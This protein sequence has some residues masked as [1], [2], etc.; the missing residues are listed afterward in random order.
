MRRTIILFLIACPSTNLLAA[1]KQRN[2]AIVVYQ[3][4]EL[5]DFAGPSEVL[6]SAA[7]FGGSDGVPALKLYTVAR[8]TGP[9]VSQGFMKIV[10]EYAIDNA[11]KPDVIVI[12]GGDSAALSNDPVMWRWLSNAI[13]NA[14]VTFTVCTGAVPLAKAGVFDGLEITTWYGAIKYT[15]SVA[16]H[17]TVKNGRR[18]VDNGRFITTAGVSAGIDGALHLTARLLGRRVAEQVAQ[19]ME[20]HWSPEPYLAVAYSFWNPEAD[21][22]GRT[23][24]VA[25]MDAEEKHWDSA[26]ENYRKLIAQNPADDT[27]WYK[28][29]KARIQSKDY[30][31]AI[32]AN[33]HVTESSRYYK[34]A[35]FNTACAYSLGGKKAQAVEFAARAIAAG[36]PRNYLDDA[37]FDAVREEIVK[38]QAVKETSTVPR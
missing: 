9:V 30:A 37:D 16:P 29:A 34:W 28:L 3:G 33:A 15:Q 36:V 26:T 19:Y 7:N 31:G 12:P 35:I 23:L 32:D 38:L 1:A 21:E 4:A 17:T 20:Y 13:S 22:R 27:A 5:L 8:T 24:Q 18:F 10:P 25:D 11:P 14:E 6:Q 2:V